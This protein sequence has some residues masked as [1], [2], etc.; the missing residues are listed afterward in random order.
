MPGDVGPDEGVGLF[1]VTGLGGDIGLRQHAVVDG[2][3]A[4]AVGEQEG[5]FGVDLT[6]FAKLPGAAMKEKYDRQADCTIGRI[7]VELGRPVV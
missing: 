6:A 7:D 4:E 2:D 5:R 1:D 3:E